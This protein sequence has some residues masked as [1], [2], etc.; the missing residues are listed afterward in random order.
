MRVIFS[1]PG[2][3]HA[4][5]TRIILLRYM[6]GARSTP[7][8]R[9]HTGTAPQGHPSH[10]VYHAHCKQPL[11][12]QQG[13]CIENIQR[14][15]HTSSPHQHVDRRPAFQKTTGK[16]NV[17]TVEQ[18]AHACPHGTHR[19]E[20]GGAKCTRTPAALRL[21]MTSRRGPNPEPKKRTSMSSVAGNRPRDS[22][23]AP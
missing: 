22:R 18:S 21:R 14:S 19:P 13:S 4:D 15:S 9:R 2:S 5:R 17:I 16:Q 8:L 12:W 11:E 3:S 20:P 10:W 7:N 6:A 1:S 23:N